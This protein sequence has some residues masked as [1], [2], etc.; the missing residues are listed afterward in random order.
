MSLSL[1][2]GVVNLHRLGD[3][4]AFAFL[5]SLEVLKVV[6]GYAQEVHAL[7]EDINSR[8]FYEEVCY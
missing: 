6:L 7:G 4:G 1:I 2:V 5:N 8:R 3:N